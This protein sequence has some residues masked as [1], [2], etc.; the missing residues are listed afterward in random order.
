MFLISALHS[1]ALRCV[2]RVLR[3]GIHCPVCSLSRSLCCA[4]AFCGTNYPVPTVCVT[5]SV[6]CWLLC[7]VGP[8]GRSPSPGPRPRIGRASTGRSHQWTPP[9]ADRATNGHQWP[10]TG[11]APQQT[12][13]GQTHRHSDAQGCGR[14]GS[15]SEWNV[16]SSA[17][18]GLPAPG[19]A[20]TAARPHRLS[21]QAIFFPG[22]RQRGARGCSRRGDSRPAGMPQA[23][24]GLCPG[25]ELQE[26]LGRQRGVREGPRAMELGSAVCG[27]YF[28]W[29]ASFCIAF[30]I[31]LHVW[32]VEYRMVRTIWYV[33]Y[34]TG[35]C[36]VLVLVSSV[37]CVV[38]IVWVLIL[39]CIALYCLYCKAGVLSY[40]MAFLLL[41]AMY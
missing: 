6:L 11:T 4:A 17:S 7:Y 26:G 20:P 30:H 41:Y 18:P 32:C 19:R 37:C 12:E 2:Q 24:A 3:C 36:V 1:C 15:G 34:C 35:F 40:G 10:P 8:R 9:T 22:V 21:L 39:F 27:I 28:V 16:A 29:C 33:M 23:D 13:A 25:A 5:L 38:C 31:V 14:A